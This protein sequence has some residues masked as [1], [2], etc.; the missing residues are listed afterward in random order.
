MNTR[1]IITTL[2]AV[3]ALTGCASMDKSIFLG[4]GIGTAAGTGIG[5]AAQQSPGSALI[6]AGIG[7]VLGG[8][9]GFLSH[10]DKERRDALLAF[11][12]GKKDTRRDLPSLRAPEASC[13][14]KDERIEGNLYYGPQIICTIE[15]P[16]IWTR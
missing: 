9:L 14:Q 7:A 4:A 8:A 16:A 13:V 5:L 12:K 6:G 10:K 1:K 2:I 15:K 3:T 11:S